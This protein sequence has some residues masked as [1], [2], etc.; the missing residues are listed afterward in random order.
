ML[1]SYLFAEPVDADGLDERGCRLRETVPRRV[2]H[3]PDHLRP[4][5]VTSHIITLRLYRACLGKSDVCA[6]RI[7]PH[8]HHA[9]AKGPAGVVRADTYVG[10]HANPGNILPRLVQQQYVKLIYAEL[11]HVL[12]R[13][14]EQLQE[15]VPFL[16]FPYVCPE[17]VLVK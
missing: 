13:Q 16:S 5:L 10:V 12:A 17:P 6:P 7:V 3:T 4:A 8:H 15:N 14:R 9:T 11:W 1:F 2:E